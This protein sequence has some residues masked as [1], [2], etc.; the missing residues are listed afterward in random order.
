MRSIVNISLPT[1]VKKDVARA[2]KKGGYA[3]TSEF[4][5]DLIRLWKE[6]QLLKELRQSQREFARGK[7]KLLKSLKDLR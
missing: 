7:G 6:D 5:R 4:F 2:V 1:D 3:T